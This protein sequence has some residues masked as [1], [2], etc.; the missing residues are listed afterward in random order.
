MKRVL[1]LVLTVVMLVSCMVFTALPTSAA[2]AVH[3]VTLSNCDYSLEGLNGFSVPHDALVI[4]GEE[5]NY[6]VRKLDAGSYSGAGTLV[7]F[8]YV[9]PEPIDLTGADYLVLEYYVSDAAAFNGKTFQVE[10]NAATR[11][12]ATGE[13][14]RALAFS[15]LVDG[16]WQNG[17]NTVKIPLSGASFDITKWQWFRVFNSN[18]VEVN[19][20]ADTL[21]G[22]R[23]M[24]L[25]KGEEKVTVNECKATRKGWGGAMQ[26]RFYTANE[27]IE[28]DYDRTYVGRTLTGSVAANGAV[29][30]FNR[31]KAY[32]LE[33]D[34]EY[35]TVDASFAKYLV[36][37]LYVSD[38]AAIKD[39][40]GFFVEVNS[41][42]AAD[43]D[44]RQWTKSF[45]AFSD[46]QLKDGWNRIMIG[47]DNE[48]FT[49]QSAND[50]DWTKVC[51]IR[52]T[53]NNAFDLGEKSVDIGLDNIYFWDGYTSVQDGFDYEVIE[54]T[55]WKNN[56][57]IIES[58]GAGKHDAGDFTFSD[59]AA[60]VTLK[61]DVAHAA[62]AEKVYLETKTGSQ[63]KLEV[64]M[65]NENWKEVFSCTENIVVQTRYWDITDLVDFNK[66]GTIYVKYSDSTPDDG[67]GGRMYNCKLSVSYE[68][69]DESAVD[70]HYTV[71]HAC[72]SSTGIGGF[73][74]DD[75]IPGATGKGC[76]SKTFTGEVANP[77]GFNF[78]LKLFQTRVPSYDTTN[79]YAVVF[80]LYVSNA[81]TLKD[82]PFD[83]E[84]TSGGGPD[85]QENATNAKLSSFV[86]EGTTWKDGWNT[87]VVPFEKL[88]GVTGGG[89]N[90]TAW[91]YV[92]IFNQG[93]TIN[94]GEGLTVAW[95]NVR[96]WDG[97]DGTVESEVAPVKV[98]D[99]IY[100]FT[101][102][103][104][105]GVKNLYIE[106]DA[107]DKIQ[108]SFNGKDYT[109][110]AKAEG[111]YSLTGIIDSLEPN[112][113]VTYVKTAAA[114]ELK[115]KITHKEIVS[116]EDKDMFEMTSTSH[117]KLLV[118]CDAN[119]SFGEIIRSNPNPAAGTTSLKITPTSPSSH[120]TPNIKFDDVDCTGMD[121]FEFQIYFSDQAFM[122]FFAQMPEGQ[123]ELC[124]GGACDNQE[125]MWDITNLVKGI[126]GEAKPGEWLTVRLPLSTGTQGLE[127]DHVNYIRIYFHPHD[128]EFPGDGESFFCVDNFRMT[129]YE[130][131]A[132]VDAAPYVDAANEKVAALRAAIGVESGNK[133]PDGAIT[134][135]NY[136]A[137]KAAYTAA[138]EA[139]DAIPDIASGEF[140][141]G[142]FMR[143]VKTAIAKYETPAETSGEPDS[144]TKGQ[145]N[146]SETKGQDNE[147]E[148]GSTTPGSDDKETKA[149]EEK[150]GGCGSVVVGGAIVVLAVVS[151]AGAMIVRKKKD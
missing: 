118:A 112:F 133:V 56:D 94:A 101:F 83:I 26:T 86:A 70:P 16:T 115:A 40:D 47:L 122:D 97:S 9:A 48:Q 20:A 17:W 117:S 149:Q 139:Q 18:A 130:Q 100:K 124:S 147:S 8:N 71:V 60:H 53:N 109:E 111:K 128:V 113:V 131:T 34:A 73:A 35:R 145:D 39:V 102:N 119:W 13:W 138:K 136:E 127:V 68:V 45:N 150:K 140:K 98:T 84:F 116:A 89:L 151:A 43:Q 110:I 96:L 123:I 51:W 3:S 62:T 7:N 80:D 93:S 144:E 148:T 104:Y 44:E 141:D 95:D 6:V 69:I 74:F 106:G 31:L 78:Q 36:F 132:I 19:L 105:L 37:D 46:Y 63:L 30:Y 64:S 33:A 4:E 67:N 125:T 58:E 24:Y 114:A 65:D 137:V 143:N 129:D 121:T 72:D 23:G 42:G 79:F 12:D 1:A 11:N 77:A 99:T 32:P 38:A 142:S 2:A 75:E 134:E 81:A 22:L 87:I 49:K 126:V 5:G 82:V 41:A 85:N 120:T 28:G 108:V 92:R 14:E 76:V 90:R 50:I 27:E 135:T 91:N 25:L 29:M 21:I 55:G 66:S 54:A 88:T 107:G 59:K 52:I 146:E 61:F 57:Y 10:L 103:D 15:D